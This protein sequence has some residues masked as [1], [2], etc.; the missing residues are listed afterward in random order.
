MSG[1]IK[2]VNK[3]INM[4]IEEALS[5][6]LSSLAD[7]LGY[8]YYKSKRCLKKTVKNLE[9]VLDFYSNK[10]NK[11]GESIEVNAGFHIYN[12][13]YGKSPA[14]SV[15]ASKMYKPDD[16]EWYDISSQ[17]K[18][19]EVTDELCNV[20]REEIGDLYLRFEENYTAAVEY[21]F[22]DKFSEFNVYLDFIADNLGTDKIMVKA[23]EIYT[24]LSD[25]M[26]AQID[27]YK[28]GIKNKKW[29]LNRNNIKYI[30]DIVV[31]RGARA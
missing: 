14:E 22:N 20:L 11:S 31:E 1:D 28:K 15:I 3:G 26:L 9:F 17:E 29:M 10:W 23:N 18:L 12:K 4:Q 2:I 19:D 30:V 8:K 16:K 5:F 25:D 6:L 13:K 21:L 27:D 7:E 24:N